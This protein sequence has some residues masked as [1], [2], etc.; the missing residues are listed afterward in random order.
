MNEERIAEIQK[1]IETMCSNANWSAETVSEC[2][3]AL[4]FFLEKGKEVVRIVDNYQDS[5]LEEDKKMALNELECL[6][7]DLKSYIK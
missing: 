3:D 5:L 4:T 6:K 2:L 7:N 1:E